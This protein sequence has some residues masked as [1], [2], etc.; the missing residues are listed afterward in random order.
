MFSNQ[1]N[2]KNTELSKQTTNRTT[3]CFGNMCEARVSTPTTTPTTP[4]WQVL[5]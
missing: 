3:Y 4:T 2:V 1:Q 5:G